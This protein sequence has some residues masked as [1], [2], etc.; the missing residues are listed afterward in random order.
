MRRSIS[1]DRWHSLLPVERDP[2]DDGAP[3]VAVRKRTSR[4]RPDF[5][6]SEI[7]PPVREVGRRN[8]SRAFLREIWA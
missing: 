5:A 1:H 8:K 4:L 3:E 2:S 7:L 6:S